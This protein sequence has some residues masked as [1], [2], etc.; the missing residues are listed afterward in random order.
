MFL[1]LRSLQPLD[2]CE[3]FIKLLFAS[4]WQLFIQLEQCCYTVT[5]Q[6]TSAVYVVYLIT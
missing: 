3:G 4:D 1:L 6:N 5:D 2:H